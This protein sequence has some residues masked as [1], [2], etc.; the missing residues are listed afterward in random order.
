MKE[1]L[2]V[3]SGWLGV[4]LSTAVASLWMFWGIKENFHEGWFFPSLWKNL[5]MMFVQYL[6]FPLIF[7]IITLIGIRWRRI[8]GILFFLLSLFFALVFGGFSFQVVGMLLVIPGILL[9]FLYWFGKPLPKKTAYYVALLPPLCIMLFFGVPDAVRVGSRYNDYD[10]GT[11]IVTGNG[12]TLAWAPEGPGWPEKGVDWEK[13]NEVCRFLSEDGLTL[14]ASPVGIW[15]LPTV[16]EAVRSMTRKNVNAGGVWDSAS[17]KAR[18]QNLP[19][20]ETPLWNP[21]SMIIYWWTA[22]SKT[23]TE[24]YMIAYNGGVWLRRKSS[25]MG[26]LGFRAVKDVSNTP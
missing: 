14:E 1:K 6:S 20:K 24:A 11:R 9:G 8:G 12:V 15:R 26:Y 7:M 2:R 5:A 16:E 23:A 13:A 17:Q 3:V 4:F 19:E 18:Y 22:E 25:R 10:F 21:H